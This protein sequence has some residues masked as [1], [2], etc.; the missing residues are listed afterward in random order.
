[1]STFGT[2]LRRYAALAT[3]AC[4]AVVPACSTG[5][6]PDDTPAE[7]LPEMYVPFDPIEFDADAWEAALGGD[8]PGA[9]GD[10]THLETLGDPANSNL[11]A[12]DFRAAATLA[13]E[14]ARAEVL[15]EGRDAYPGYWPDGNGT[16]AGRL[17]T[18]TDVCDDA[19]VTV[20]SPQA[21]PLERSDGAAPA[22]PA[23]WVKVLVVLRTTGCPNPL[24][25][26]LAGSP[27]VL[28]VYLQRSGSGGYEPVRPSAIPARRP[29]G[30]RSTGVLPDWAL[31]PIEHCAGAALQARM[32][33]AWAASQMCADAAADGVRIRLTDAFRDA[34]SQEARFSDAVESY[35]SEELARQFVAESDGEECASRHCAG[36]AIDASPTADAA[37][38]LG[39]VIGCSDHSG[40]VS[41]PV[42]GSCPTGFARVLRHEAYGFAA[43]LP[44]N[45]WHL[46][47]ELP[48]EP[49]DDATASRGDCRPATSRAVAEVI[50]QVWR[51]RLAEAG[52]ADGDADAV[53]ARALVVA[54][55][56]SG[57]DPGARA[58][59]G[60]YDN[61]P[62]PALG[63]PYTRWGLFQVAPGWFEALD[64]AADP[65]DA[66]DNADLAATLYLSERQAGRW[67]FDPFPC[68]AG[69]DKLLADSVLPERGGPPLPPWAGMY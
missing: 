31:E 63:A 27:S 57:W 34:S 33:V 60:R 4:C 5:S 41:D 65:F 45:P 7:H 50:A 3:A 14:V 68:A 22:D 42:E 46:E 54:R 43:P 23:R 12:G 56:A 38:W 29:V 52:L 61:Q 58:F 11:G 26:Q 55:C 21:L 28:F 39:A 9:Q 15:G 24:P 40:T 13:S 18:T 53:V 1:M 47:Y 44:D 8:D 49:L 25:A 48:L 59:S 32:E 20:A 37:A 17:A 16:D 6:D 51:C 2:L 30:A 64:P 36:E 10:D 62:H 66:A 19:T 67:G 69:N 35:G